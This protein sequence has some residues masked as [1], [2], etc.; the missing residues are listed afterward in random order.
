MKTFAPS[1]QIRGQGRP[2]PLDCQ[3]AFVQIAQ[4]C[5]Q[6]IRKNRKPAMAAEPEA[7]HV[8]RIELTR[9]RAAILFFSPM[10][11]DT[12]WQQLRKEIRWLNKALGEAR[13]HDVT[14]DYARQ[15]RYARWA[16]KS[17]PALARARQKRHRS[18]ARK[19]GS[20]RY[21]RLMKGLPE[22]IQDYC[23]TRL[24]TWRK[25]IRQKGR[26]LATLRSAQLHRLRIQCKR[27]R[28]VVAALQATGICVPR[29][30]I[31]FCKTA[32]QMHRSLGDLRDLDRL[33]DAVRSD[34]PGY[35]KRRC[36]LLRQAEQ[37]LRRSL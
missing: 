7:I 5:I 29:Q 30:E 1:V 17:L 8:M 14:A 11:R 36:N 32:K 20:K 18:L 6:L 12:D 27:Y 37:S 22:H 34:P 25:K 3:V 13:D 15:K 10:V 16:R 35:L 23:G 2:V 28:Y 26:H 21:E 24:R 19:L 33:R 31:E 4:S 9:L